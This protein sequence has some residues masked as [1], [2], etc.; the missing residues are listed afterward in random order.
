V[1]INDVEL[2]ID[3]ITKEGDRTL[4]LKD[5]FR[6]KV[7]FRTNVPGLGTTVQVDTGTSSGPSSSAIHNNIN[8]ENANITL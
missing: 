4:Y 3:I 8:N 1:H 5:D 2:P 7:V 6:V